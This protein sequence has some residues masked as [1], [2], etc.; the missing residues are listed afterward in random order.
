[1]TRN[2][3]YLPEIVSRRTGVW[4]DRRPAR[5]PVGQERRSPRP[6]LSY[7]RAM[8]LRIGPLWRPAMCNG[9]NR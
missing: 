2:G 9:L 4:W 6:A 1:L 8:A 7:F 5:H 3:F